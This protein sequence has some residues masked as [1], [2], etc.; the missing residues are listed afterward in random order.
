MTFVWDMRSLDDLVRDLMEAL[1]VDVIWRKR[2]QRLIYL[3][4]VDPQ[5]IESRGVGFTK[6]I[7]RGFKRADLAV[8]IGQ[9][10]FE[11]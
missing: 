6:R 11:H 7:R 9:Q 3:T 5:R 8:V 2:C 4:N 1:L 10:A